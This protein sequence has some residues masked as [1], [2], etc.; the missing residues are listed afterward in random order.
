[1][2]CP[3]CNKMLNLTNTVQEIYKCPKREEKDYLTRSHFIF[4]GSLNNI[5]MFIPPYLILT[6]SKS[7]YFKAYSQIRKYS[8]SSGYFETVILNTREL[9]MDPILPMPEDKLR[10]RIQTIVVFS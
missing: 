1:M 9:N 6:F 7:K 10:S 5:S 8:E 3:L 4:D 2:R